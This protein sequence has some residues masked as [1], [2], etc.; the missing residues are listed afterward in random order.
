LI[1]LAQ[2]SAANTWKIGILVY[3]TNN[4]RLKILTHFCANF[5]LTVALDEKTKN[6]RAILVTYLENPT[7]KV[8]P[9][10]TVT[11]KRKKK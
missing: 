1:F 2:F 3:W 10:K 6:L 5:K 4:R 7:K 8:V 9:K 11:G